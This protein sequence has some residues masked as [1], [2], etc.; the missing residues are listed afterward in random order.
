MLA[1]K[2]YLLINLLLAV[3]VIWFRCQGRRPDLKDPLWFLG[4]ALL[5]LPATMIFFLLVIIAGLLVREDA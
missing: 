4:T 1:L 5:G 2:I 3:G